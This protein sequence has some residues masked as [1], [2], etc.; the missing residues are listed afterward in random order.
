ML[1][2]DCFRV[3]VVVQY[4]FSYVYCPPLPSLPVLQVFVACCR[5]E[6]CLV[7]LLSCTASIAYF[8]AVIVFTVNFT[9]ERVLL[10]IKQRFLCTSM[11]L[12]EFVLALGMQ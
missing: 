6:N 9:S 4:L 12:T 5:Y 2:I 11:Q 7:R 1:I 10:C 8:R 3:F